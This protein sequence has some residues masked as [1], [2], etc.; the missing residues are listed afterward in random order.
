L[1]VVSLCSFEPKITNMKNLVLLFTIGLF[2]SCG[3]QTTKTDT[4]QTTE[5]TI[6]ESENWFGVAFE[7][8]Q[9]ISAQE[10]AAL[11]ND[12]SDNAFIVSGVIEECCQKKG[13]WMKVALGDDESMRVSFK[14]Y[15]FFVPLD[16]AGKTMTMKGV[17]SYDTIDVDML[18]HFAEDAGQTQEEI[19]AIITPEVTLAFE[20]TGVLIQ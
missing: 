4:E 5:Q 1:F 11:M 18:K 13:C 15:G 17:A 7:M 6:V 9:S 20:A 19:D 14:D 16:V 12:R 3:N 8:D 10:V 2:I